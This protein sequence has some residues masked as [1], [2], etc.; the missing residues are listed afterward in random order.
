MAELRASTEA[1]W[2]DMLL[3]EAL[4]IYLLNMLLSTISSLSEISS[5][6]KP[7]EFLLADTK[8]QSSLVHSA[9]HF[10]HCR[11]NHQQKLSPRT[12]KK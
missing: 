12:K 5:F 3:A 10:Q 8:P 1:I 6:T 11:S 2:R 7:S 9:L 4:V